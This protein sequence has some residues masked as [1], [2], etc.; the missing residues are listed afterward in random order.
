MGS[1]PSHFSNCGDDCPVERVSWNDAK[2]FVRRLSE[3]TG[4]R[5][6]LPSEAEWEYACRA[7]GP[8]RYC[9]SGDAG[10]VAWFGQN[11]GGR[12]HRV[13]QKRPNAFGLYDM[14]GNVWEWTED[15]WNSSYEGAPSNGSAWLSGN[16]SLRVDRGGAWDVEPRVVRSAG[17]VRNTTDVRGNDLGFRLARTLE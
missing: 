3:K 14:S 11:S 1:N 10:S 15:C 16:C 4:K 5:Y 6:R 8:D 7:G 9:G 17:R 12:T 2:E 13:A